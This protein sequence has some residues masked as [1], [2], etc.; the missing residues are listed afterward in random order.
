M[1][2]E[3]E[4]FDDVN[5]LRDRGK[6]DAKSWWLVHGAHAKPC[7]CEKNWNNYSFMHSLKKK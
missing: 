7:S 6:M 5:S 3:K 2:Y 1:Y 4:G